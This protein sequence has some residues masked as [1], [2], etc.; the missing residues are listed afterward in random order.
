MDSDDHV[1][2][3]V[4]DWQTRLILF[5]RFGA[6]LDRDG[7]HRRL[8]LPGSYLVRRSRSHG[9]WIYRRPAPL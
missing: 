9:K 8:I 5:P 3:D 4:Y 1:E 7:L 6:W 2:T